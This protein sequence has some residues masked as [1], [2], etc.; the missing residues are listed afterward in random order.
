MPDKMYSKYVL[1]IDDEPKKAKS[2]TVQEEEEDNDF[3][4]T[5]E[6]IDQIHKKFS[7][8]SIED[9][10]KIILEITSDMVTELKVGYMI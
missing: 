4:I 8:V 7:G 3:E 2:G 10:R 1:K 6:V 5:Q 9:A